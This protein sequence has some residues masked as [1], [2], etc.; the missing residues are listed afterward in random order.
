MAPCDLP[1]AV[2]EAAVVR[3]ARLWPVLDWALASALPLAGDSWEW[4]G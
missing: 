3:L 4:S 2:A 1:V